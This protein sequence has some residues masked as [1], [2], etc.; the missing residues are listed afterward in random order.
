MISI[1]YG[2]EALVL[3]FLMPVLQSEWNLTP[4][5]QSMLGSSTFVGFFIGCLLSGQLADRFGRRCPLLYSVLFHFLFGLASGF[6]QNYNTLAMVRLLY[7]IAVGILST[8]S[9]TY[10]CEIS[11]AEIRG[12]VLVF[13]GMFFTLGEMITCVVAFVFLND[14]SSGN[15]RALVIWTAFP[16]MIT[17]ILMLIYLKESPRYLLIFQNFD[18]AF[19]MINRMIRK[20]NKS[21]RISLTQEE[22]DLLKRWALKQAHL[23]KGNVLANPME[24]FQ[25][26]RC[27]ITPLIWIIWY[28][29]SCTYDGIVFVLPTILRDLNIGKSSHSEFF[30]I[31]FSVLAEFPSSIISYFIIEHHSF[32]RKY[33]LIYTMA[34]SCVS[35]FMA[36]GIGNDSFIL[37]ATSAR[38]WLNMAWNIIYPFT[39]EVYPT[40]VRATGLGIASAFSRIGGMT[41]PWITIACLRIGNTGPFLIFGI[42]CFL[43]M[44]CSIKLPYD[45]TGMEL[46]QEKE[47]DEI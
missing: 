26:E 7:G 17:Y 23:H 4:I 34:L 5:Q 46:D 36:F 13:T 20:N 40:N 21:K 1:T 41:M 43:A 39:T 29:L 2:A 14:F 47:D 19:K 45:T 31:F 9:A 16:G 18:D 32:G 33:S 6:A 42:L 25:A 30:T 24:L 8:I 15:W 37:A 28:V 27:K 12:K 11:P 38:F 22:K 3:S 10:I 44:I 35:C